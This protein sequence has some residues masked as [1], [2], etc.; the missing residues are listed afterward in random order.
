MKKGKIVSKKGASFIIGAIVDSE[1]RTDGWKYLHVQWIS[2]S[3]STLPSPDKA[4]WIRHDEVTTI[5]PF[6][7]LKRIQDAMLLSSALLSEN[8][9]KT[10]RKQ[11]EAD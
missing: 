4:E 10:L 5:D 7:E 11:N 9:E 1:V 3:A 2:D 6:T 8:F